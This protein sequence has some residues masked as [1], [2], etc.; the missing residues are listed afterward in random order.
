MLPL[1]VIPTTPTPG[2]GPFVVEV[3]FK[4]NRREYFLTR[5]ASLAVGEYVVVD[6]ERGQDL[7]RVRSVGG[8]AARKCSSCGTS[9]EGDGVPPADHTVS[10][11]ADSEEVLRLM[12]LRADEER[13]R[14]KAREMVEQHKLKM[15]VTETE[16]QWDRN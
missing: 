13:V 2:D 7:G 8:V 3:S 11:R 12:V 15:K 1:P 6:V 5:E 9:G 4:G 10:R 14:R 16:W